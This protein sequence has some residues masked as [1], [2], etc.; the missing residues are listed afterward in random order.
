MKFTQYDRARIELDALHE[1]FNDRAERPVVGFE[2]VLVAAMD[3]AAPIIQYLRR[4][5]YED[6]K[7][8]VGKDHRSW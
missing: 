4:E 5:R 1:S 6:L 3:A 8:Q 2:H 7:Q